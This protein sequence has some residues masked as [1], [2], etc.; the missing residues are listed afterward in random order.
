MLTTALSWLCP[1]L[2]ALN[3]STG[4]RDGGFSAHSRGSHLRS[5][6]S[7]PRSSRRLLRWLPGAEAPSCPGIPP[8]PPRRLPPASASLP[9]HKTLRS[10][11][12]APPRFAPPRGCEPAPAK[13]LPRRAG[14]PPPG[15]EEMRGAQ[16][17]VLPR[18][19]AVRSAAPCCCH[20][21]PAAGAA[22]RRASLTILL[23]LLL[24]PRGKAA[25]PRPFP[26]FPCAGGRG[27]PASRCAADP[28]RSPRSSSP[29]A[30]AAPVPCSH[31]ATAFPLIAGR[32]ATA[33]GSPPAPPGPGARRRCP[34]GRRP[35]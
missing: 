20:L 12:A 13:Q 35:P 34:G 8:P 14:T 10:S 3:Y 21:L 19:P 33:P 4:P 17:Q 31:R 23:V 25:S 26:S 5:R 16:G 32:A 24:R 28:R 11:P 30:A 9:T 15:M 22:P 1:A 29:S 2:E 27:S 7:H 6:T 18:S